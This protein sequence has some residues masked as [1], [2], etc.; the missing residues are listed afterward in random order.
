MRDDRAL[1]PFGGAE[2]AALFEAAGVAVLPVPYE[3]SVSYGGGTAGGPEAILRASAQVEL[4]DE[5]LR[6]E[7]YKTGVHTDAF[8]DVSGSTE[9]VVKRI[10]ARAGEL[11][12]A[13]K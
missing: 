11:M 12:D 9:Q 4:W 8:L 5:Q 6:S 1:P 2:A 7:P 3:A 13:G 10:E